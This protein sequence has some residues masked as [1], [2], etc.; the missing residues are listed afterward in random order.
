MILAKKHFA[1]GCVQK[2]NCLLQG[3]R[4]RNQ[5]SPKADNLEGNIFFINDNRQELGLYWTVMRPVR[6]LGEKMKE[7]QEASFT[8]NNLVWVGACSVWAWSSILDL[9]FRI[10][11]RGGERET[12]KV[13]HNSLCFS[14][15]QPL[16]NT[17]RSLCFS[18]SPASI[19][20][21][22][23]PRLQCGSH[24]PVV[25][26]HASLCISLLPANLFEC[27]RYR[28]TWNLEVK[29]NHFF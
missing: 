5:I 2:K 3:K 23:R 19:S 27:S 16:L 7:P 24:P 13:H 25:L 12:V 18:K 8:L 6:R 17:E 21:S 26:P 9:K 10:W 1:D 4:G 29:L 22:Y 15:Q 28:N 14:R 11:E 20:E